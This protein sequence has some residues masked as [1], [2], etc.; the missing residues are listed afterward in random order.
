MTVKKVFFALLLAVLPLSVNGQDVDISVALSDDGS[1]LVREVWDL[2][3][4]TGTEWYLVRSNLGDIRIKDLTVTDETGLAF[5]NEGEWDVNRS[6][7]QKAGRCGIVHK[8]DGC[9]ICWGLGS[10]GHHVY[11]VS[12]TMTNA[13]KSMNDY[14][15]LHM[16]FVSPGI[17]PRIYHAR[18]TVS[19]DGQ[20]LNDE[21]TGI[22]AFGYEGTVD[23]M[24][25][26]IVAETDGPFI[27]DDYSM[28]VLARFN[29]GLFHSPSRIDSDFQDKLDTAF[30]GSSY[31]EYLKE[32]KAARAGEII[33][34]VL[35]FLTIGLSVLAAKLAV[36][37]RNKRMFGVT[38]LKD[39]GYERDL[40]FDGN[41]LET[42][43]VL[44]KCNKITSE[45]AIASAMILRMIKNGQLALTY[46]DKGKTLISFAENASLDSLSGPEKELY[47]MMQEASGSDLILQNREFSRWSA[48]HTSRVSAWVDSLSVAGRSKMIEDNYLEGRTYTDE[49]QKH[50]RRTIGFKNFLKDFT[51]LEERKS[52][53][54]ALWHD[55][56]V[57]A[58]LFGIADKVAKELKDIDPKAFEEYVGLPYPVMRNVIYSTD[59]MGSAITAAK[60]RQQQQTA[61]SVGGH[62][63]F[64]SFGGGGGFSGGGFGGGAR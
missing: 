35:A 30:N 56:I 37:S 36:R 45:S 29:K 18:V 8:N 63:G 38:S 50:A 11:T 10:Y 32:Q 49:G 1:A 4:S 2:D 43:Y 9:E 51:I 6:M 17:R 60:V 25:G 64:S 54:V 26:S 7:A 48:R 13:V 42:R 58:A 22:W 53:E 14:D 57:M 12:Y 28:I 39:I 19:A 44:G 41:L 34:A 61:R 3:I 46:D 40:P 62:G 24:E 33:L 23:F 52:T 31:E 47:A 59:N 5:E 20:V 27:T 16:Q 55:Y 21:N 15:A